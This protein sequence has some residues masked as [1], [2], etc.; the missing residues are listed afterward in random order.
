MARKRMRLPNGF[1]QI[2]K[3][4]G[5]L[6]NPYRAMVTV[7]KNEYGRPI[8]KLLKPKAYFKTYN[9]AYAALLEYN[10]NPFDLFN[11]P[12]MQDLYNEWSEKHFQN[13]T[14]HS[15]KNHRIAWRYCEPLKEL[16]VRQIRSSHLRRFFD[17]LDASENIRSIVK[18]L[19][20][21]M[22][23]YAVAYDMTDRN[24]AR[25]LRLRTSTEQ[26]DMHTPFTKQEIETMW[27][28]DDPMANITLIQCYSGWRPGEMGLLEVVNVDLESWTIIGGEKTEAGKGRTVPIHSRIRSL[29]KECYDLAISIDSKYLFN[30]RND[31]TGKYINLATYNRYRYRFASCMKKLNITDHH[32]HDGRK[33]FVTMAKD[34]GL[35][36]YAIKR[37][38]GHKITD[39]TERVYTERSLEWLRSEIEK[40]K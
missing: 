8:C 26:S 11:D 33:T 13:I 29:V 21:L 22:F 4:S 15:A 20:N 28:S 31:K 37:I 36:E 3:I 23:D 35:N 16:R 7:G 38:V 24:Y 27:S 6:R 9:E 34:A 19:L 18:S 32:A 30:I 40:I 14:E 2:S 39:L 10:N 25:Q 17:D 1:G 12:T 5:N